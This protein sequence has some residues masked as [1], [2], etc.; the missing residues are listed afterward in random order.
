M[1]TSYQR[2]SFSAS[3]LSFRRAFSFPLETSEA[4]RD[5]L[6]GGV[7]LL[8]GL[9]FGWILN[10]GYR[11]AVVERL[12]RGDRP[13]FRG[14]APWRK[15]FRRGCVAF[16]AIAGYLS[17]AVALGLVAA[18]LDAREQGG[19]HWLFALLSLILFV[20]AIFTLPGGMTVY[21][22]EGTTHVLSSPKR[23]FIRAWTRRS[24]YLKA[25]GISLAAVTLSFAG[26]LALG[27]GFLFTSVWAW[28]V[29]GYAFTIALYAEEPSTN[30]LI[31]VVP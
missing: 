25:W 1:A 13:Y 21:A 7:I 12:V 2:R 29:V 31:S 10:L 5:I 24:I 6:V 17:P 26:L 15:T 8:C 18:H 3:E 11:L 16:V 27:V 9:I 22:A 28:E 14:F 19:G 30:Q 4:R 23:A 20:L